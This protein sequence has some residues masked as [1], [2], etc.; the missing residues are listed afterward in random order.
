MMVGDS[1]LCNSPYIIVI[2]IYR[3]PPYYRTNI[4]IF[5]QNTS[6]RFWHNDN[7]FYVILYLISNF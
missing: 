3:Q 7:I 5:F 6:I 2:K 1:T 4:L